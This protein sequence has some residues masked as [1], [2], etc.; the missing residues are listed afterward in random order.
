MPTQV[1]ALFKLA[2]SKTSIAADC[3]ASPYADDRMKYFIGVDPREYR[4]EWYLSLTVIDDAG[5]RAGGR[6]IDN[7]LLSIEQGAAIALLLAIA[8]IILS[9]AH[10]PDQFQV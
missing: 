8:I 2:R 1:L 7:W 6:S 4:T 3:P 10:A 5:H 9:M